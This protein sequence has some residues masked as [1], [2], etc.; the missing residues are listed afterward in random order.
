MEIEVEAIKSITTL[1]A[2]ATQTTN[3]QKFSLNGEEFQEDG[4]IDEADSTKPWF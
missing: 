3:G 1:G 2:S 4:I